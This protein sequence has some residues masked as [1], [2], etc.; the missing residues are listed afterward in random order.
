MR[1]KRYSQIICASEW[2]FS[3][4]RRGQGASLSSIKSGQHQ[5]RKVEHAGKRTTQQKPK[6]T[7]ELLEFHRPREKGR[8]RL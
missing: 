6:G 3:V 2:P 4:T 8:E 5:V 1:D 7:S